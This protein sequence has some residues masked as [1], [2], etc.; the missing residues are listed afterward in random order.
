MP[1]FLS[2]GGGVQ[3][4]TLAEMVVEGELPRITAAIFADTGNEPPWVYEHLDYLEK[5]LA[6]VD[7]P[8]WRVRR[9]SSR[10]LVE[11][12]F[13]PGLRSYPLPPFHMSS[14]GTRGMLHRQCTKDYKVVPLR[15]AIQRYLLENDQAQ[16]NRAGAVRVKSGVQVTLWLGISTDEWTRARTSGISWLLHEYPLLDKKMS[17]ADCITWLKEHGLPIP[18]KSSCLICPY[19]TKDFW[20]DLRRDYPD[21]WAQVVAID[22]RLRQPL[23]LAWQQ[24]LGGA[25]Y[26]HRSCK[27]MSEAVGLQLSLFAENEPSCD[28][29]YCFM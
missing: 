25:P 4:S 28:G 21:L 17:R 26:I 3:S 15:Q 14:N 2:L 6:S 18:R 24:A 12:I 20:L 8:L 16:V 5:R 19:H 10:G 29:G 13:T 1:L 11:D 7:V 9:N 27:P 23:G 22:E